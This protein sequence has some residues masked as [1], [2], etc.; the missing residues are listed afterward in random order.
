V[1]VATKRSVRV[2]GIDFEFDDGTKRLRFSGFRGVDIASLYFAVRQ[3]EDSGQPRNNMWL[4]V[5]KDV[6]EELTDSMS[7]AQR[8]TSRC[9]SELGFQNTLV[10]GLPVLGIDSVAED[11]DDIRRIMDGLE[12]GSYKNVAYALDEKCRRVIAKIMFVGSVE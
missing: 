8:F 2:G 12:C 7:P 4:A 1:T 3:M 9:L 5:D 6:L 11:P 10:A